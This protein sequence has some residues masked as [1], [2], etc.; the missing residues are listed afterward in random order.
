MLPDKSCGENQHI[1]T[2]NQ[3]LTRRLWAGSCYYM[4][5]YG[6]RGGRRVP[7]AVYLSCADHCRCTQDAEHQRGGREQKAMVIGLHAT[8][9]GASIKY[10]RWALAAS[11]QAA[12][13][14]SGPS[15][16]RDYW[17]RECGGRY[18]RWMPLSAPPKS[19]GKQ[20]A[21]ESRVCCGIDPHG[22]VGGVV[23]SCR[24]VSPSRLPIACKSRWRAFRSSIA[25]HL[26][27]SQI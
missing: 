21:S 25:S 12:C 9:C 15:R 5:S 14:E 19:G 10:C 2:R 20:S 4:Y 18:G 24:L 13:A 7:T 27:Q 16:A 22:S 8:S 26:P 17:A 23:E 1:R 11:Q 3:P 6:E